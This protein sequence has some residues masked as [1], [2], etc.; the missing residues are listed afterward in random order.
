MGVGQAASDKKIL[1]NAINDLTLISGQKPYITKAKKSLASFK[2]RQGHPVG[3]KVTLRGE[4]MWN[5]FQK[6][7]CIA[8]PRIRDFRGFP[9]KSFDQF[10]NYSIGI[11][12]Q[13]IF[14]EIDYDKID[15]IRG[16]DVTITTSA[17]SK[18]E[19]KKVSSDIRWKAIL[20]LQSLPR[21]SS[22]SRQRNRCSQTARPRAF[23][24]KFGLSRIKL[25]ESAMR[26]EIPGLRKAIIEKIKRISSPGLRI[27][28]NRKSLPQVKSG[29][30]IAIISTSKGIMT[31]KSARSL[32]LGG[33]IICYVE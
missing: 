12:E 30:G 5:F 11:K 8:I 25:R 20:Q 17:K 1:E 16:L 27:Y 15:K 22:P 6:L 21:D 29:M 10:G 4:R 26:G 2:I 18:Q 19:D 7:V 33:E 14:P 31:D 13:I 23:L 28:K 3:C 9:L 24:R 32:N